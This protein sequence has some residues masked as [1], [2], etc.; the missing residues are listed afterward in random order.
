MHYILSTRLYKDSNEWSQPRKAA[1]H[2]SPLTALLNLLMAGT[3]IT[4]FSL[5]L[6][7]ESAH[8]MDTEQDSQAAPEKLIEQATG[9]MLDALHQQHAKIAQDP[10]HI[11]ALANE[12]VLPHF[13]L[14]R[15]SVWVLG[16]HWRKA[17]DEQKQQFPLAFRQLLLRTYATAMAEYTDEKIIILPMRQEQDSDDRLVRT[18]IQRSAGPAIPVAYRMYQSTAGWKVYDIN[19]DGISLL[20]NY[21]RSFS[22]EISRNGLKGLMDKLS[23]HHT[24]V[25]S[26]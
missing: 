6:M 20:S 10:Q 24:Q 15:M 23:S 13:D 9:R 18:E 2:R 26:K 19:I 25:A 11:F 17:T 22:R 1:G 5:L 16:K 21:R 12:I 3:I 4:L 7:V 8:A 14:Q